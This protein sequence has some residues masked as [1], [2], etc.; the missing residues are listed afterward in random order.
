MSS[1]EVYL[2]HQHLSASTVTAYLKDMR[3]FERWERKPAV[4][5]HLRGL[6]SR[7]PRTSKPNGYGRLKRY[8]VP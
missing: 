4:L 8:G 1:F 6:D 3:Y 5:G 2:R 7:I